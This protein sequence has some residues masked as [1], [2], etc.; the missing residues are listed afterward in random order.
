MVKKKI[1]KQIK[2]LKEQ[3]QKHLEKLKTEE[4]E[5]DTTPDY[6]KKEIEGFEKEINK[7]IKKLEKLKN[8][9]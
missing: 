4:G 8:K 1:E 5:K 6:W 2:S 7:K 9:F 3:K